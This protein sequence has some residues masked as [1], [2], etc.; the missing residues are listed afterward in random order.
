MEAPGR[1]RS[2]RRRVLR[3]KFLMT[4]LLASFTHKA[5]R[6]S[7]KRDPPP[8]RYLGYHFPQVR[9]GVSGPRPYISIPQTCLCWP[10]DALK[11]PHS[12]PLR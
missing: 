8:L 1:C 12:K 11:P 10:C 2:W 7:E 6:K 3:G 5:L 9:F 4:E